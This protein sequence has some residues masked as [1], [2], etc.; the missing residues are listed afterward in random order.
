[1]IV[2]FRCLWSSE[3]AD[4]IQ[5]DLGIYIEDE[6]EEGELYL[7]VSKIVSF[8]DHENG[9]CVVRDS[10]SGYFKL[11]VSSEELLSIINSK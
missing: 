4:K 9:Y 10:T 5:E 7:D 8:N 2:R 3:E 1:M 6:L 11:L